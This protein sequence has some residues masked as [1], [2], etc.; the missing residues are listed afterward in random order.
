[1]QE[2]TE[3]DRLRQDYRAKMVLTEHNFKAQL[4]SRL[5]GSPKMYIYED[6]S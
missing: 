6:D 2:K 3:K 5:L 1:M 4:V